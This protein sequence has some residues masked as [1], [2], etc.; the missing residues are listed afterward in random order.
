MGTEADGGQTQSVAPTESSAGAGDTLLLEIGQQ[1]KA[2]RHALGFSLRDLGARTDLSA[3]SLSQIERG[4]VSP[5][6]SSLTSIARALGVSLFEFFVGNSAHSM[7]LRR[8]AHPRLRL[9]GS[10]VNYELV[11][12]RGSANI[13]VMRARLQAGF[14]VYDSPQVHPQE[15][16][17]F[18]LQGSMEVCLGDERFVLGPRDSLHFDGSVPH[19][20]TAVGDQEAEYVL[21]ISPVIF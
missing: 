17:L 14:S 3:S 4:V 13:A 5:T 21:C 9:P 15:E 10:S 2:R 11:S 6:L 19:R 7:V 18:V 1:I 12:R 20:L 16:C 8:G